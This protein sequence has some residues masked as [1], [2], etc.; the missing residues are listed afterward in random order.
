MFDSTLLSGRSVL[1]VEDME[2]NAKLY[3][4]LCA[5][6]GAACE[7]A[8]SIGA[9]VARVSEAPVDLVLLDDYVAG[10]PA[11]AFTD[12]MAGRGTVPPIVLFLSLYAAGDAERDPASPLICARIVKPVRIT[13]FAA[14]ID[15]A[16]A[17]AKASESG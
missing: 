10:E 9:A 1:V 15:Q 14:A 12:A 13:D 3:A 5:A 11:V 7:T 17:A 4:D 6:M 8:A 16:A 2:L